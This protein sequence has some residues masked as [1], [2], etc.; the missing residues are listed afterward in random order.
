M[1]LARHLHDDTARIMNGNEVVS[2]AVA[3]S[4]H[5]EGKFGASFRAASPQLQ[6][7]SNHLRTLELNCIMN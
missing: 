7:V 5:L 4:P 3:S 2:W 1:Y 6:K